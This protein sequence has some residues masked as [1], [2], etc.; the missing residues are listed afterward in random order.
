MKYAFTNSVIYTAKE[1]L[2]GH[3]VVIENDKIQTYHLI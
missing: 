1:V 3:A 2:Y